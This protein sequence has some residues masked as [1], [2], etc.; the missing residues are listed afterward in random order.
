MREIEQCPVSIEAFG[1]EK[2]FTEETKDRMT[3]YKVNKGDTLCIKGEELE[4]MYFLLSGKI[5]IH[6]VSQEGKGL[7][8][9]FKTPMAIIGDVEYI[10]GTP[11]FH[12]VEA[13]TDGYLMAVSFQDLKVHEQHNTHF[14]HFLLEV[15]S[16]K[17]YTESHASTLNMLY[18][19]DV[20]L[21]SYL[22]SISEDGKGSTFHEEMRTRNLQEFADVMGT[23]YRHLNRIL[24]SFHQQGIIEK[25][26]GSIK[27]K[28]LEKLREKAKGNIYE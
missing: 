14:L 12:T 26:R 4:H 24:L 6:T 13:V 10:Q 1:L 27:I 25:Q 15:I 19:V 11:V 8:L 9:R 18:P 21:A 5:K 28:D 3:Y 7:I 20:R 17:F 16:H 23:S 22:L 2:V